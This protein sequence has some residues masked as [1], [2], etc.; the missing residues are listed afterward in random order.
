MTDW[1]LRCV[2]CWPITTVDRLLLHWKPAQTCSD[3]A[4]TNIVHGMHVCNTDAAIKLVLRN[5]WSAQTWTYT[6]SVYTLC[7]HGKSTV[8]H[9]A[10]SIGVHPKRFSCSAQSLSV[11]PL[12]PLGVELSGVHPEAWVCDDSLEQHGLCSRLNHKEQGRL[13]TCGPAA[14]QR[15]KLSRDTCYPTLMAE[16][17]ATNSILQS[18]S[19]LCASMHFNMRR[20]S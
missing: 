20:A 7:T 16:G 14:T 15:H 18:C 9:M 6:A 10:S 19:S 4:G 17:P 13:N 11:T 3:N 5:L 8:P 12:S 1:L 2:K